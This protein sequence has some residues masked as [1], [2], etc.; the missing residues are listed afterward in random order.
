MTD[1]QTPKRRT[2]NPKDPEGISAAYVKA[3]AA[4]HTVGRSGESHH[5]KYATYDGVMESIRPILAE[6]G[7]AL[8]QTP[9][10]AYDDEGKPDPRAI[11]TTT[12]VHTSG[13]TMDL[14]T[15]AV[16]A[17]KANDPQAFGSALTYA[18]RYA[19]CAALCIP[20]GDDDDGNEAAA[21]DYRAMAMDLVAEWSGTSGQDLIA[22]ARQVAQ[23]SGTNDPRGICD[24]I[25][26]NKATPFAEFFTPQTNGVSK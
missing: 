25:N 26:R 16:P 9:S 5:G 21:T 19:L 10:N 17:K 3:W 18:K 23:S 13:D 12:L 8:M 22:A 24:F 1:E 6:H 11:I 20:T 14:G 7:L 15:I 4:I 2:T